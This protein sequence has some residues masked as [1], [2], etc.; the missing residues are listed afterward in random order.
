MTGLSPEAQ[1]ILAARKAKQQA[2]Q[3]EVVTPAP[4]GIK[5]TVDAQIANNSALLAS[6][7]DMVPNLDGD[8]QADAAPTEDQDAEQMLDRF[9]ET[10]SFKEAYEKFCNKGPIKWS[11]ADENNFVR[12]P[13][14]HH[15]DKKPSTWFRISTKVWKCGGC[16]DGGGVIDLV[17][18]TMGISSVQD[19]KNKNYHDIRRHIAKAYG[20]TVTKRSNGTLAVYP[21]GSPARP[22]GTGGAFTKLLRGAPAGGQADQPAPTAVAS[23]TVESAEPESQSVVHDDVSSA[24]G[25]APVAP[26][27]QIVR[28]P[29]DNQG[30]SADDDTDAEYEDINWREVFA[31]ES[32]IKAYMEANC[33]DDS[34]E[35]YHLWSALLALGMTTGRHVTLYDQPLVYGN[36]SICL[37][38]NTGQ[39]KSRSRVPLLRLFDEHM[40]Y[41]PTEDEPEGVAQVINPKTGEGLTHA[42]AR[43][44]TYKDPKTGKPVTGYLGRVKGVALFEEF[45]EIVSLVGRPG[46][47]LDT[48]IMAGCDCGS[49]KMGGTTKGDGMFVAEDHYMSAWASTQPNRLGDLFKSADKESGFL[50]RWVFVAGADKPRRTF[51]HGPAADL[52]RALDHY[53]MVRDVVNSRGDYAYEL[54]PDAMEEFDSFIQGVVLP[55]TKVASP[56]LQRVDVMMKKLLLL[57]AVNAHADK[58]TLDVVKQAKAFYPYL[59]STYRLIDSS[60]GL[61]TKGEMEDY[62]YSVIQKYQNRKTKKPLEP[63]FIPIGTLWDRIRKNPMCKQGGR[64]VMIRSLD[65]LEKLKMITRHD[66]KPGSI[67]KPTEYFEALVTA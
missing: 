17:G 49:A 47:T 58:V 12:C 29:A 25:Q 60:I 44:Q 1:A 20:W 3:K 34:P 30:E 40:Q 19:R 67:G 45:S 14:L 27:L 23:E 32:F 15:E 21:P 65:V 63:D 42:F 7:A 50:N 6:F 52:S 57:L 35:M 54:M 13:S 51:N 64:E 33:T 31:E 48:V 11:G 62:I 26:V 2:N 10:L 59:M 41:D 18:A 37:L 66:S 9:I 8:L 22:A 38:G 16:D 5:P 56:M 53:K 55:E 28:T 24:G 46:S 36:L 61:P 4:A 43:P 39:G